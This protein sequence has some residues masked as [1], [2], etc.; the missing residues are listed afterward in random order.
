MNQYI[1]CSR[2]HASLK[3]SKRRNLKKG[4][5]ELSYKCLSITRYSANVIEI[6]ELTRNEN[7]LLFLKN[8][9]PQENL[10]NIAYVEII[11]VEHKKFKLCKIFMAHK[12]LLY[13][14]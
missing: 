12:H 1:L 7:N 9:T 3:N 8:Q 2:I 6:M 5:I 13:K 11:H 10:L 14:G 4:F